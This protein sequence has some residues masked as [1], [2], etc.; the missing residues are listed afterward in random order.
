MLGK[1][2]LAIL[3]DYA[4][5]IFVFVLFGAAELFI[6]SLNEMLALMY[7]ILIIP[8]IFLL[9]IKDVVNGRS[10]GKRLMKL[11]VVTTSDSKFYAW[12]LMLRN[13]TLIIWPIE[14]ILLLQNKK[15][16]GDIFA[17]TDVVDF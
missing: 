10:I 4:I 6:G 12:R 5:V 9:V 14:I 13:T 2:I 17:K 7:Y 3:I 16:L 1:R 15:R 11:K 8:C